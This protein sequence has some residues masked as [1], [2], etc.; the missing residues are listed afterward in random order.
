MLKRILARGKLLDGAFRPGG[1]HREWCDPAVLNVIRRRSLAKV[2]NEIEPVPASVLGRML[3]AWQGVVS[4]RSGQDALLDAIERLQGLALPASI[5]ERDILAARV[6]KYDPADLDALAAAGDVV[7]CGVEPLGDHDGRMALYL[8]DQLPRRPSAVAELGT[9]EQAICELLAAQ[10]ASF[11]SG[12]HEGTGGGF[13]KETIDALWSLVWKGLCTNDTFRALRAFTR[14]VAASEVT[15]D[16]RERILR[17]RSLARRGFHSRRTTPASVEGRW[18]LIASRLGQIDGM[19][20]AERST[21]L[22]EQLL[23]RYGL[24]TR[25]IAAAEAIV[26]GFSAVYD[27]LKALEDRGR[28]RRGYFVSGV[29]AMQFALPEVPGMLRQLRG[30]PDPPDVVLLAATDPANP[31][32]TVLA[33]PETSA[34]HG[35][36]RSVGAHVVMVNGAM[37]AYLG[38]GSKSGR[39]LLLYVG[40]HSL[41]ADAAA[42]KL[43]EL[44]QRSGGLLI[45][46]IN[47]EAATRHAFSA[48]LVSA[49]FSAT[50]HGCQLRRQFFLAREESPAET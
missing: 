23:A 15:V 46:E 1:T 34:P 30:D 25:E 12:I 44:G 22:A 45:V 3:T 21:R 6:K 27:V 29:G 38:K 49:G 39:P 4:P 26:G 42:R 41:A 16:R 32:G 36:S 33:W 48:H 13:P 8:T 24:V 35:P 19:T 17:G 28:V 20:P 2:R 47:G 43:A 9:R 10:G 11:F 50:A 18:S 14:G 5:L 31:Y 40:E 7:W 37:A